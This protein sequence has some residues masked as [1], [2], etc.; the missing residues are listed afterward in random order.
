MSLLISNI[1]AL[2]EIAGVINLS[3]GEEKKCQI[4]EQPTGPIGNSSSIREITVY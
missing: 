2:F 3:V 4:L 1:R